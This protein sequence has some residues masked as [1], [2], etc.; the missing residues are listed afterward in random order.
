MKLNVVLHSCCLSHSCQYTFIYLCPF[1]SFLEFLV[2]MKAPPPVG[3]WRRELVFT[4]VRQQSG[5][6]T[7]VCCWSQPPLTLFMDE[8]CRPQDFF[9]SSEDISSVT[10]PSDLLGGGVNRLATCGLTVLCSDNIDI[11]VIVFAIFGESIIENTMPHGN[12]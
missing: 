12:R 6:I 3:W 7:P 5:N 4:N 1:L 8:G 10:R 11:N 2:K 9:Q